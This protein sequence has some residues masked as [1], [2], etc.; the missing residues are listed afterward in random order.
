[1]KMTCAIERVSATGFSSVIFTLDG[2]L[3]ASAGYEGSVK[4]WC[5]KQLTLK[6]TFRCH[7]WPLSCIAF[8]P[9]GVLLAAGSY[10][11]PVNIWDTSNQTLQA[12]IDNGETH[13]VAFSPDSILLATG[14]KGG[15]VRIWNISG[16][17]PSIMYSL[18]GHT[19]MVLS[20]AFNHD[21]SLLATGGWDEKV[22]LWKLSEAFQKVGGVSKRWNKVAKSAIAKRMI[23]AE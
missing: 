9:N 14:C 10:F 11:G 7:D 12:S 22:R 19:D 20:M 1:M 3:I 18:N 6:C 2:S 4:L 16:N 21:G 13:A 23:H 5:A 15:L 8:N 17:S